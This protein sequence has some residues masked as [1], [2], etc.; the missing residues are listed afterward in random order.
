MRLAPK[1]QPRFDAI[2]ERRMAAVM[3]EMGRAWLRAHHLSDRLPNYRRGVTDDASFARKIE[4]LCGV[5]KALQSKYGPHAL[6]PNWTGRHMMTAD[7]SRADR[8]SEGLECLFNVSWATGFDIHFIG[9]E[10]SAP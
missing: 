5:E 7:R 2:R 10:Q 1:L 8:S 4:T 3:A 6:D 9:N